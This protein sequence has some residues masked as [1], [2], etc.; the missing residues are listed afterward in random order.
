MNTMNKTE[1]PY[2]P[3]SVLWALYNEDFSDLTVPQIAEVF[4]TTSA[5]IFNLIRKIRLDTGY[6]VP[7][8]LSQ[9]GMP[10]GKELGPM[11]EEQKEKIRMA[12]RRKE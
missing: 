6:V 2:R 1:C 12:M 7:H 10:R 11:S 9:R 5:Y 3:R 4:D 8:Q